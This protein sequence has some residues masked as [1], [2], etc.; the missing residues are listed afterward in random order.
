MVPVFF[1]GLVLNAL[2]VFLLSYYRLSD[3]LIIGHVKMYDS[4]ILKSDYQIH[5]ML[6]R[7]K[8]FFR[9]EG[10]NAVNRNS[11]TEQTKTYLENSIVVVIVLSIL[12]SISIV[13]LI[14]VLF[15]KIGC[16]KSPIFEPYI[17]E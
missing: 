14:V 12:L 8:L 11:T 6:N 15:K 1:V 5:V 4:M 7:F 10:K 17:G 3:K 2:S 16:Y 9:L 13:V